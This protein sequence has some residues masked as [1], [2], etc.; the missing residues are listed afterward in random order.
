M[1]QPW[2]INLTG[3]QHDLGHMLV[4]KGDYSKAEN[5]F[6]M[7][8]ATTWFEPD[9][10]DIYND[11]G[12]MFITEKLYN[13]AVSNYQESLKLSLDQPLVYNNLEKMLGS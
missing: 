13:S 8:L 4:L 3:P 5:A 6:Q 11:L 9:K 10:K 1:Q 12:D 7:A 2:T